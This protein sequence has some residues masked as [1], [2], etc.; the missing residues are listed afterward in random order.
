MKR[1][2][3][4]EGLRTVAVLDVG[5]HEVG[6]VEYGG[7][8]VVQEFPPVAA[9]ETKKIVKDTSGAAEELARIKEANRLRQVAWRAR[10]KGAK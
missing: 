5:P 4:P 3:E 9:A 2:A 8:V 6:G 1:T 10:Q 7:K